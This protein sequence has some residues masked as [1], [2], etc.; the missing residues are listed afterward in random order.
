V[1]KA[2]SERKGRNSGDEIVNIHSNAKMI[3]DRYSITKSEEDK[4]LISVFES[5]QP[6]KLRV[7]SSK[8]K[9]KIVTLR[10]IASQFEQGRKYSE[11]EVNSTLIAI[12]EDF[13]TIRRYLIEYRFMERT[14]DCKEYWL[15]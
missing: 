4:I 6:L 7:F 2:S 8:E 15:K 9:K 5:L 14:N 12:Y 10:K 3:D 11:K 1:E 13:A